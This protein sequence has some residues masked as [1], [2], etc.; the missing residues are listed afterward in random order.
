MNYL[1]E[2]RKWC[3]SPSLSEAERRELMAI[4]ADEAEI[5]E[6]FYAPLEFGTAGLRGTMKTGL[7]QMNVHVIRWVTQ[8]FANVICAEGKDAME[9]GVAICM[10]CRNHSY[11][12]AKAAACVVAANGIR[13]LLF[14]RLRPTPELSF[15]IRSYHCQAGINITASHNP[16][17]YNGY[18]VYWEDGAQLP[19]QR[20]EAV[21]RQLDTI[22]L[23]TGPR[24]MKFQDAVDSGM[25]TIFGPDCDRKFLDAVSNMSLDPQS[26]AAVSDT[27]RIVYTP[28]HGCGYRLVPEALRRLGL[29]HIICEPHQ[30]EVDGNFPTVRSPNPENPEGFALAVQ[31][32]KRENA[33]LILGTDP[34]CDRVGIMIKSPSGDYIAVSGNQTG[35]LLLDYYIGALRRARR[36]PEHAVVLKT[37]VT[38]ELARKIATANGLACYD[39]FTGFKFMAEKMEQLEQ[40]GTDQVIFSYEE[41]YGYMI[42][43]YVRDK[44][45]VTASVLLAE[46][47]AWYAAQNMTLY[48][49]LYHLFEKY[50][51]YGEK[52]YHIYMHGVDGAKRMS[53]LVASLRR[54]PPA[55]IAGNKVVRRC[56]YRSGT[57][58]N[59]LTGE[60]TPI[61]PKGSNVLRFFLDDGSSILVRPSG[62]EPKVKFYI[63]TS[64]K[65]PSERDERI[66][67]YSAWIETVS[68]GPS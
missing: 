39:T 60:S 14:D 52:T 24:T 61:T 64:G 26:V 7:H 48:D 63:L 31:L 55:K 2:Y 50:G 41:S 37:I 66:A 8:G 59:V 17:E 45:A 35:A 42:G 54:D 12:F 30:M 67:K 38:T 28:F 40:S 22:D 46:M 20:A 9:R 62:T 58:T 51:W 23:F 13:V 1:E 25:I 32:A 10:D 53:E 19:P 47:A 44:D 4:Q 49:A 57:E 29:K 43:H 6:R 27:L 56:D 16:K 21:S 11:E 36:L 18:K 3:S 15:A 33:D 68:G 34:D 5:K 65:D